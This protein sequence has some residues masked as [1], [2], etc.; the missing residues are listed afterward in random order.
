MWLVEGN[1]SVLGGGA[2]FQAP[3]LGVGGLDCRTP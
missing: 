2:A 1:S 3:S